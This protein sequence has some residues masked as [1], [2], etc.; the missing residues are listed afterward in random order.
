MIK[1]GNNNWIIEMSK[2][3]ISIKYEN[4]LVFINAENQIASIKFTSEKMNV[5]MLLLKIK[6]RLWKTSI[7]TYFRK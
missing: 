1:L 6:L 2:T 5:V 7:K 4:N 3:I